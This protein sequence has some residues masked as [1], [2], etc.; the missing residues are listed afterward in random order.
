MIHIARKAQVGLEL[1]L[2]R[3]TIQ[4]TKTGWL[5]EKFDSLKDKART[6]APKKIKP[7]EEKN[8][9]S[10]AIKTPLCA[11][12]LLQIHLEKMVESEYIQKRFG[13]C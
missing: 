1:G 9:L 13:G 10:L 7:E 8:L 2:S 3:G 12:E 6:G 4:T 5:K 11:T